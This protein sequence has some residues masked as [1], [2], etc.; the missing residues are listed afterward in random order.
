MVGQW[1]S[2]KTGLGRVNGEMENNI[3]LQSER[4]LSRILGRGTYTL[5]KHCLLYTSDAA[6]EEPSVEL[7]GRD[8]TKE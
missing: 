3:R 6:D 5:I 1:N 7:G 2:K 4:A 8:I